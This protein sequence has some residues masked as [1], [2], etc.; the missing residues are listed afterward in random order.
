MQLTD[1]RAVK[2]GSVTE[3]ILESNTSDIM[4]WDVTD[5]LNAKRILFRK[6]GANI[7]FKDSS[8]A[9]RTYYV[10]SP[11]STKSPVIR[12]V[13]I[14]NQ[15]LHGSPAADMII[16]VHPFFIKYANELA[17]LHSE[18]DNLESLVV[19]PEQIYNEFSGGMQDI[20]AIRNFVRMKFR[21]QK[22]SDRPL[23]YLL[24][25]G[26]GSY[27]NRTMPPKNPNYIPTYQSQNSNIVV[28]SYTSD[29]FY[30]LLEE[31][32]GESE[33]T[34]DIG[35]GRLPVNDTAQ[36]SLVLAKI[37]SYIDPVNNGDWK[38]IIC[39][40]ADDED[41]NTHL[42]D[43][44]SLAKI[45]DD[46]LP[47]F[48]VD[49]I[50]LD[51]FRQTTTVSG[52][53]YPNVNKAI[54]DRI[55]SG[56]L[57][58]NY[59]GHGSENGLAHEGILTPNDIRSWQN[60]G[61]LPLFITATCEFS[62]FDDMEYN[63]LTGGFDQKT[64]AGELSLLG[65]KAGA[66]A[67]MSTTRVVYSA[68]NAFLN[69]NI[70]NTAFKPDSADKSLTLGDIIKIAKNKSGSGPNKRNFTLLGDPALRL[71][72]PWHGMVITDSVNNLTEG[73]ECDTLKALSLVTVS[74]HIE[75]M[76]GKIINDFNGIVT[77]V[78]YDKASTVR[79]L[80]NDGGSS[81]DFNIRNNILFTGKTRAV[82]GNF[83]F[84]FIVPR[85]INYTPGYGKISYYA[86]SENDDMQGYSGDIVVGGFASNT[87]K[88]TK[89]PDIRLYLNDTLFRN[90]GITTSN[91]RLIA[92]I[93]D[94]GGIN[95]TGSG[96]GHD[97]T[98]FIDNNSNNSFVL[99]EY[100]EN[101]FDNYSR[102]RLSYDLSSLPEGRHSLTL[103]AWDNFNNSSMQSL[104]FI[105]N[106]D[107]S[108]VIG[109]LINYP[110]PFSNETTFEA[111]HNRPDTEL[112]VT[113]R[114]Y[115]INGQLIKSKHDKYYSDGFVVIPY[116]WDGRDD[117]GARAGQGVYPYVVTFRTPDGETATASGRLI[118]L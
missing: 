68:P 38:N 49:K 30:G 62:R 57:I 73:I 7:S 63:E 32:E 88:D 54:N 44:E 106:K 84:R 107:G 52:Q 82:N 99:N 20:V 26:D 116:I 60:S 89:G 11:G 80:A 21:N 100:F 85:D 71:A 28:S 51:A 16:V 61:K 1:S 105:V 55:N 90:G 42:T 76:N 109:N 45:M 64:S 10:F 69:R 8:S 14:P 34:E 92:T 39:L 36:A 43:A 101:D 27:E 4:I 94:A 95:T 77:P 25:F 48:N 108:F 86:T 74:G 31:N 15:D 87:L 102:G 56:C 41:G 2:P 97:I 112:E 59:T 104:T 35:I 111:Q 50:Y 37:R 72:Y 98:A 24:L 110:N 13:N 78:V 19:T 46:S 12:S 9:L 91:P 65:T 33:G 29:D 53:T 67:L 23:R 47:V 113:I 118:I 70:F 93:Q 79:T 114:I 17:A 6:T 115:N 5:N 81:V 66:I 117:K 103:K 96:I 75:D 3:F 83:S 18:K 58:F 22:N 40:V